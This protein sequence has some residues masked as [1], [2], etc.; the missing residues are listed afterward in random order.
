VSGEVGRARVVV[1]GAGVI[2]VN[3]ALALQQRNFQV[4]V[5]DPGGP[6]TAT[7][8]GSAGCF[9]TGEVTPIS[10]PGLIWTV[11][12]MLLD[13]LGPLSIRW[14]NIPT[15]APWL[16][17]FWRAGRTSQVETAT[18]A[19]ASLVGR[20]WQDWDP[21]L[22]ETNLDGLV[23]R[24][25]ALFVYETT[26]GFASA[27]HEWQLRMQ[28]GVAARRV[29]RDEIRALEPA[30]APIF[31]DGYLVE[32]WGHTIDPGALTKGLAERFVERGGA[33]LGE[34][35]IGFRFDNS[36]PTVARF[37]SGREFAFDQVVIAA[38]AWSGSLCSE[39]GHYVPLDSERGYNT[40]LPHPGVTLS[41]PVCSAERNFV[42]T[43]MA[44]GLRIGGAVELA[45]LEAPPNFARA[46]AL[47]DLGAQTLP[48]LDMTG[49]QEWMGF[50]PSMPDSLPV[51]SRSPKYP[52]V[53]F[54][55]GHGHLGLTNA[56][57][58]GRLVADLAV[59]RTPPVQMAPF[60]IDRF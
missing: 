1:I 32:D 49:G 38:G 35:A 19:L 55:F 29:G 43:P 59:G 47:L 2:G 24:N 15:L 31:G 3:I 6:G 4:T 28:H 8:F 27:A 51:I 46:K 21:I 14:R 12:R 34:R 17:H 7:S 33:I 20:L 23:R 54:A 16:W 48:G 44:M 53:L 13:P 40:T 36:Q 5:V 11:P 26:A 60:R 10:M 22:R 42:M 30:L 41:R 25:G 45:S 18:G 37:E 39:L 58:T 52:N 9:A 57:T 56:A 50:R